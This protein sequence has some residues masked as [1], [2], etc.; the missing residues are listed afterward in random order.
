MAS[1]PNRDKANSLLKVLGITQA[2][3]NITKVA[4]Y[5]GFMVIPYDFPDKRKGMVYIEG[6]VKV[7]G[8]NK[9]HPLYLQNYTIAHEI[10]HFVNG[11]EHLDND[12]I[13]D[14]TRFYN[15]HFQ[16]EHEADLFASEILMPKHFL[17]PHLAEFGLDIPRLL[18][19]YQVSNKA[20]NIR[21]NTLRLSEKYSVV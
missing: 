9:S 16:Q 15:H 13:E 11:H 5:L 17:E 6:T 1:H 2:P 19:L 4:E 14:D 21:L 8:T 18:D 10:G 20:L 12:F 7:I 3:V